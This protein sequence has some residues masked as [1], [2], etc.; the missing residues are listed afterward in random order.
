MR[1]QLPSPTALLA[2]EASARLLSFKQAA[3]ELNVS[4][5]AVSRQIHN[6]EDHLGQPLFQRLHRQVE[7]T[8][9]GEKLFAPVTQGFAGMAA[10]VQSLKAQSTE[11]QVTVGTTGGFAFYWLMPRLARFSDSWPEVKINQIVSDAPMNM[12]AGQVE[13]AVRYGRGQWPGLQSHFLFGDVIYPV[14]SPGYLSTRARPTSVADLADH[15]LYDAYGIQGDH[16]VTWESWFRAAGH[17]GMGVQRH[18][19]NYLIGVQMALDGQGFALGWHSFIGD[20]VR[21]GRLIKPI[22]VQMTAPGS[23]YLTHASTAD[24]SPNARL[25]LDWLMAEAAK[26]HPPGNEPGSGQPDGSLST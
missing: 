12:A 15:P 20:L 2:F 13:L 11:Q 8:P 9:A 14:C 25:V 22:D 21:Q 17:P 26:M 4:A 5:A 1:R 6:L 7:L 10:A 3:V 23:F 16:W 18:F 24:L 19:L